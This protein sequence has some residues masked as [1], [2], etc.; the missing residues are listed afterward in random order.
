MRDSRSWSVD[1]LPAIGEA[2]ICMGAFDGV[3]RG[4]L[5]LIA[6]TVDAARERGVRPVALVFDPHPDEVV[7]PGLRVP[8]LAPLHENLRRLREAGIEAVPL[9]FDDK[10]RSLTAEDFLGAMAPAIRVRVLVMTPESAFGR[11]RAGTPEA[12]RV[13]GQTAGFDISVIERLMSDDQEP[14]SSGRIRRALGDGALD[15][16]ALLL[17]H[18]A[19][20]EGSIG[21]DGRVAF[22]YHPA[23]PA[24]GSYQAS[25]REATPRSVQLRIGPDARVALTD[26]Q[27]DGFVA[28]DLLS[29]A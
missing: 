9:R 3:H 28:L 1:E 11:N 7:R 22:A 2:A 10:L 6:A 25:I 13:A 20:L 18:P 17:G 16:A 15:K 5:A 8:R 24:E 23:L 21:S 12:L 26:A 14:I 29:R 4:H 19:Y 27:P